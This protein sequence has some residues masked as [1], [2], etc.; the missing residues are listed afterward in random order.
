MTDPTDPIADVHKSDLS[1][2][3]RLWRLI[4]ATL[5]PRAW[6]HLLKLVNYYNYTHVRPLRQVHM[7]ADVR[8]S[9]T[10]SLSNP[11]NIYLK[12]RVRIG[13]GCSIWGGP[14]VGRVVIGDDALFGPNVMIT[15]ASYRIHDGSPVTEQAMKE[16]DVVL[17]RDVWVGYGAVILAGSTI[18][19]G[20][21]IGANAVVRGHVPANAI[22]MGNP[23]TQVGL[24]NPD[25]PDV[26]PNP[27][28]S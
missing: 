1:R 10:V 11:Q 19:D 21:V 23:A 22:M 18:E 28:A 20:A 17:G 27:P 6:G 3:A 24:R 26:Q 15:A 4:K 2:G 13:A 9:P 12:D 16:A 25:R 7:G 8:L 14:G 5:D